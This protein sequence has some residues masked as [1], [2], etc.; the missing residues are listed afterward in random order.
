MGEKI[1]ERSKLNCKRWREKV[2][3]DEDKLRDH[4]L[5]NNERMRNLRRI[6]R[7]QAEGNEK[8]IEERRKYNR[9]RQRE[10]RQKRF[11]TLAKAMKKVEAVLP[12]DMDRRLKVLE[13]LYNKYISKHRHERD[14]FL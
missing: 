10:L 3:A 8:I 2:K 14:N 6:L 12:K 7:T 4:K 9:I 1:G 5:K 11:Q 13:V